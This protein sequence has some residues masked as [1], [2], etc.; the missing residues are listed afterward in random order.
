MEFRFLFLAYN[1]IMIVKFDSVDERQKIA[2]E[3]FMHSGNKIRDSI[4][5]KLFMDSGIK[6]QDSTMEKLSLLW[7]I[8]IKYYFIYMNDSFL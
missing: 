1:L 3:L 4:M 5:E 2:I 7:Y 8:G 6:I